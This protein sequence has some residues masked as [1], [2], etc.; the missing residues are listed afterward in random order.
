M[1]RSPRS[2]DDAAGVPLPDG[3]D[4][5]SIAPAL[6]RAIGRAGFE[7]AASERAEAASLSRVAAIVLE[8]AASPDLHWLAVRAASDELRHAALCLRVARAYDPAHDR[9]PEARVFAPTL[10]AVPAE[11]ARAL[12]VLVQCCVQETLAAA[13]L[14]RAYADAREPL[15]RA[16]LRRLLGDEVD[17][18]RIGYAFAATLTDRERAAL[19]APLATLLERCVDTWRTRARALP[20]LAAPEHGVLAASTIERTIEGAVATL[21]LPGLREVG[22]AG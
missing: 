21:V 7:H 17:H 5:E 8:R 2:L 15:P 13:Y 22:L 11:H 3:P 10:V 18:G 14:E 4:P 20:A 16:V 1:T 19:R 6:R 9:L 12:R